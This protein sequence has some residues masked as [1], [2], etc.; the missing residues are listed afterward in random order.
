[1]TGDKHPFGTCESYHYQDKYLRNAQIKYDQKLSPRFPLAE[2]GYQVCQFD[3]Q[4]FRPVI[5]RASLTVIRRQEF[6]AE[7]LHRALPA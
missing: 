4:K 6:E 7:E 5:R 3:E 2:A 1:M